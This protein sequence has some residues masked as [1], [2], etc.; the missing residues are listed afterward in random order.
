MMAQELVESAIVNGCVD[1]LFRIYTGNFTEGLLFIRS[2]KSTKYWAN[3]ERMS[4][5]FKV[6]NIVNQFLINH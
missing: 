4:E 2:R 5:N 1:Y 6:T 3:V